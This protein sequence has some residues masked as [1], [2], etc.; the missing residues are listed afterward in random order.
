LEL[1]EEKDI[2]HPPSLITGDD[3]MA[4]GYSSGPRVGHI[5][6]FIRQKQVEDEIKT[7]EGAL[8]ILRSEFGP[9]QDK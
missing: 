9:G 3:V 1:F 5:L 2:V 8:E 4:L 6:K 7:R